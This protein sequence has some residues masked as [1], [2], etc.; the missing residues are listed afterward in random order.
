MLMFIEVREIATYYLIGI[1]I[2]NHNVSDPQQIWHDLQVKQMCRN[3]TVGQVIQIIWVIL[4]ITFLS[5]L[6]TYIVKQNK[7][8]Y[9]TS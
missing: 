1:H 5:R 8:L 6:H 9:K 4:L 7:H 3:A 2:D